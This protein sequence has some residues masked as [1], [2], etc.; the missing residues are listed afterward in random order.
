M[1]HATR[2]LVA[3]SVAVGGCVHPTVDTRPVAPPIRAALASLRAHPLE[4]FP[5]A[6]PAA[7][8][9]RDAVAIDIDGDGSTEVF[10]WVAPRYLQT[11]T[12]VVF[13]VSSDGE[14]RLLAEALAPGPV[15]PAR[16]DLIGSHNI[17]MGVEIVDRKGHEGFSKAAAEAALRAGLHVVA[18]PRFVH[19]DGRRGPGSFLDLTSAKV[20]AQSC[21]GLGF[22][23]LISVAAGILGGERV[24]L[25]A[26]GH[27][28]YAYR[29]A[30][31]DAQGLFTKEIRALP[32]PTDFVTFAESSSG[33]AVYRTSSGRIEPVSSP[34]TQGG[35]SS[36]SEFAHP[37]WFGPGCASASCQQNL[38]VDF[39]E[40]D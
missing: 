17:G 39:V 7:T 21:A 8:Q 33:E 34:H 26:A 22:S 10:V 5:P 12:V 4:E 2:L 6:Q 28:I 35:G 1:R 3:I 13:S 11:P 31:V 14:V 36:A 29:I 20:D 23:E 32:L 19:T 16:G 37:S 15:G 38:M 18:Y 27:S 9:V 40:D 24:F 30:K 25:A